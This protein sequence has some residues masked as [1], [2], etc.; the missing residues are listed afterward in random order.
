MPVFRRG[1]QRRLSRNYVYEEH[2]AVQVSLD[3]VSSRSCELRDALLSTLRTALHV[4]NANVCRSCACWDCA[5]N[6]SKPAA[7][8][9]G[10]FWIATWY[11]LKL[12]VTQ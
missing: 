1:Y 2:W 7:V 8:Q 4:A 9:H 3:V 11:T 5:I 6:Y 12:A 10:A